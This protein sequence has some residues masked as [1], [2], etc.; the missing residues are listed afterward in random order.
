MATERFTMSEVFLYDDAE[1]ATEVHIH[2]VV[3]ISILDHYVRRSEEQNRVIGTLLGVR[4]ANGVVQ[5]RDCFPV[6]HV[7]G[8]DVAV[9]MRF[10]QNMFS[11]HGRAS[12]KAQIVGW[13]STGN[14]VD[15][16]TALIHND[17]YWGEVGG[18]P[19]HLSVDTALEGGKMGIR[20]MQ[21]ETYS[22]TPEKPM[23]AVFHT[24]PHKLLTRDTEK[25]GVEVLLRSKDQSLEEAS[26]GLLGDLKGLEGTLEE[27]DKLLD[28]L[29]SYT[30]KVLDGEIPHDPAAGRLLLGAVRSLP[31]IDSAQFEGMV[32]SS[33]QDLLMVVYLS[34]LTKTQ[35][36]ISEKLQSLGRHGGMGGRGDRQFH[37]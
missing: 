28:Q 35:L 19:I 29:C 6:P 20:A 18:S 3:I 37:R 22:F 25:A 2:P 5:V 32:Q 8:Q 7:E 34:S 27:L 24:L 26:T 4:E 30:K 12:A 23:M 33:M 31:Q 13:Y 21:L 14:V 15:E 36:K 11:L 17:F 16:N 10:H 9:D 1:R